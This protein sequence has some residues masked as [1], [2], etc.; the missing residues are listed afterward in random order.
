MISASGLVSDELIISEAAYYRACAKKWATEEK[1]EIP[2]GLSL[3]RFHCAMDYIAPYPSGKVSADVK[4][5]RAH[6]VLTLTGEHGE[7]V[8]FKYDL[9]K[10]NGKWL[11]SKL[12][13]DL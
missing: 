13:C 4:G 6:A 8:D 9:K 1:D 7:S 10:E 11:L 3:D 2:S 12:G 5:D